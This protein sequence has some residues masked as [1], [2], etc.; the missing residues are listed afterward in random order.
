MQ[1]ILNPILT[2]FNPDPSIIRVGE[3]YYIAT[4]TFEWFPGGTIYHSKDL[5]NWKLIGHPLMRTSQIDL[6]G[7]MDS[8]GVWAPCLSYCEGTYYFLYSCGKSYQDGI[9]DFENY[10]IS[11]KKI[12]GEWSE[13]IRIPIN[14]ADLSL[15]HDNDGR[16]WIVYPR[17]H[18]GIFLREFSLEKGLFIAEEVSIFRGTER[19]ITEGPHLY[20]KG[21]Y[22]Y[23]IVAEGGTAY[24]HCALI[25]RSKNIKGPYEISPF[26]P[27]LS[28]SGDRSL[29]LQKSGHGDL[30]ELAS[31]EWGLVHLCGRPLPG[32]E[33]CLLGRETAIQKVEWVNGWPR[34]S[35][36]IHGEPQTEVSF[37]LPT[38]EITH[39]TNYFT[40]FD[41]SNLEIG[42]Q[43]PRVP[44]LSDEVDL[45][46]RKGYLRLKGNSFLWSQFKTSFLGRRQ[47]S[48]NCVA[49]IK[50][51]VPCLKSGQTAGLAYYYNS[52]IY[53]YFA[54]TYEVGAGISLQIYEKRGESTKKLISP[55]KINHQ[56][57]YFQ[58]Q[59]QTHHAYWQYS[60]DGVDWKKVGNHFS[61]HPFSD[62][63]EIKGVWRFTGP[64]IGIV[65]EDPD[66]EGLFVD[67]DSYEL[68]CF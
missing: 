55:L 50:F 15:F 25:L 40:D 33:F 38:T 52:K 21:G 35:G 19:G 53:D 14:T 45:Q 56:T 9:F 29:L 28:S 49:Q 16:H 24:E 13:S 41:L 2:G 22:Y 66:G 37:N 11:T 1:T 57:L 36:S 31:G 46:S 39:P 7:L 8:G 23:L 48:W 63:Y 5:K 4:S 6:R 42:F 26:T 27:F 58:L 18:Q 20:N 30:F 3:D 67:F 59:I 51:E 68:C 12:E 47:S 10:L 54:V 34:I 60:E 61:T 17:A 65:S 64:F 44:L 32:T 43:T 62:D